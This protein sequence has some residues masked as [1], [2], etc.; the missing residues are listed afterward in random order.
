[1]NKNCQDICMLVCNNVTQDPRVRKEAESL[2]AS[3]YS[4]MVLGFKFNSDEHNEEIFHPGFKVVRVN[5]A[6][7]IKLKNSIAGLSFIKNGSIR[8]TV[9]VLIKLVL[10]VYQ[11]IK[12]TF[13][14]V[15]FRSKVYHAHDLDA[16]PAAWLASLWFRGRLVYDSHELYTEQWDSF[17]GILKKILQC[18]EWFLIKRAAGVITVNNSIAGE[19]SKR[20]QV[21]VPL[22]L[23]NLMKKETSEAAA[24]SEYVSRSEEIKILYHGGF[25]KGRGLE[26]LI[27]SVVYWEPNIKLYM[28]GFGPIEEDLRKQ[29]AG[30]GLSNRIIFLEPVP[31]VM[32]IKESA[33]ADIGIMPYKPTCLN[34]YYSLPNKLF[35]YMMAGLAVAASDLPEIRALNE[36]VRFGLLFDPASPE[37][38]AGAVNSLARDKSLLNKCR[39][40]ARIWS[41]TAGNW[42]TES[43]KLVSFYKDIFSTGIRQT[44]EETNGAGKL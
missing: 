21:K 10:K 37:S 31:M 33:F 43:K 38:I 15:K 24:A 39:E 4:V 9:I 6:K 23:R 18:A 29:V 41:I 27:K 16:L 8:N 2:A 3:A 42:E 34:N 32:L 22:T 12:F 20:Y 30:F 13:G 40:N 36:E 19:L 1:M 17:P 11:M 35:E 7:V 14:A 44:S 5:I 25:S 26:E 28:R